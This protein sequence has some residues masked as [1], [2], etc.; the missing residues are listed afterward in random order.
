MCE[1][2]QIIP[3]LRPLPAHAKPPAMSKANHRSG[4]P[5][6]NFYGRIR[7]KTL[8][9]SQE[10][11]LDEDLGKLSPGPVG[12][13]ENP[14]RAPLDLPALFDGRDVWLEIGFGGGEHMVHQAASNPDVGI[15][16]AEPYIN[17][18][19]MMLGKIRQAGCDNIRIQNARVDINTT[20]A[21]VSYFNDDEYNPLP[22]SAR[23]EVGTGRTAIWSAL[24]VE[25][26]VARVAA[27]G[28]MDVDGTQTLVTLGYYD[29]RI[30][31]DAVTS[32]TFRERR[33]FQ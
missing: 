1:N 10:A 11:Y 12:W 9:P 25:P 6:R 18:V 8:R 23:N 7:G 5:W 2:A 13:D 20:R 30:Y 31:P 21:A 3:A 4:A 27:T 16:G 28:L 24:N 33:P 15:I 14:D 17:G 32:V 22:E 29:V 26:G 19:A